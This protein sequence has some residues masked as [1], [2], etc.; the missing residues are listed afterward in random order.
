MYRHTIWLQM[1]RYQW[2][3]SLVWKLMIGCAK[4]IIVVVSFSWKKFEA[5]EEEK[6]AN[7]WEKNRPWGHEEATKQN[8]TPLAM[9]NQFCLSIGLVIGSLSLSLSFSLALNNLQFW[10]FFLHATLHL[11][12]TE[13]VRERERKIRS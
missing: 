10:F 11:R 1:Y 5:R 6:E 7:S 3:I 12:Q 2:C 4:A 9:E 8:H 13:Q